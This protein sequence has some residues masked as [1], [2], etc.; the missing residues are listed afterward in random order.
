MVFIHRGQYP[1][2]IVHPMHAPT[3]S[4]QAAAAPPPIS[5]VPEE[6]WHVS[7]FFYRIDRARLR[8]I[9]T[10]E[11]MEGLGQLKEAW[12]GSSSHHPQRLQAYLIAGHKADIG[13]VAMDPNP[14][15]NETTHQRV[16]ASRVGPALDCTWSFV[17]MTEVSEYVPTPE[18]FAEKLQREGE[19]AASPAFQAKVAGYARRLP[20]M[21]EQ[22]LRPE[23]P[24]WPAVCF[25]PMN[26]GRAV[27]ANWFTE[28]FSRRADMMTEHGHSGMAFAGRVTQLIS[29]GI[30]IDD[31]EWM[32]TLWARNPQYL[33]EIVY[34]MRFDEASAR[35]AEFGPFYVGYRMPLDELFTRTG[36]KE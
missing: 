24:D 31:W 17:S 28:P 15:A 33:K 23:I 35:Y 27:G 26:K 18:Q 32:V 21:N 7:H 4:P 16:M 29:V 5:L 9:G 6:G 36:L 1:R 25:Y 20:M 8:E 14:L 19:D 10:P 13:V 11:R 30:G 3:G 22:R 12:E 34:R 2:E